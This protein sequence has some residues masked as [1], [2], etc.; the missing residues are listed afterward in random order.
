MATEV[1]QTVKFIPEDLEKRIDTIPVVEIN[2]SAHPAGA[3]TA[4]GAKEVAATTE[5]RTNHWVLYLIVGGGK[6]SL[7]F[8]LPS[9]GAGP[10][11]ATLVIR[12]LTYEKSSNEVKTCTVKMSEGITAGAVLEAIKKR[13]MDRYKFAQSGQ[14]C[15]HWN[16]AVL[17]MLKKNGFV[18]SHIDEAV[19]G[20]HKV[21]LKD[22]I[23]APMDAQ[24]GIVAGKFY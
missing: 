16:L 7:R 23:L 9:D 6:G 4:T 14:G 22:G 1:V 15:R 12:E 20:L 24:T 8:D 17:D 3:A 18:A 19:D 2:V 10:S 11:V 5:S 13:G 21:W